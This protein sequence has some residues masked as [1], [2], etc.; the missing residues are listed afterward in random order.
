MNRKWSGRKL[1]A[2][3][4]ETPPD[5]EKTDRMNGGRMR[6]CDVVLHRGNSVL[7]HGHFNNRVYIMKLARKMILNH[8]LRRWPRSKGKLYKNLRQG[9]GVVS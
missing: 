3:Y 5:P 7:Q 4:D 2:D 8:P 9:A 6:P 1:L